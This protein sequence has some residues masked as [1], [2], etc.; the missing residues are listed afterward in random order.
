[1]NKKLLTFAAFLFFTTNNT[2]AMERTVEIDKHENTK[3]EIAKLEKAQTGCQM[4]QSPQ[5]LFVS[6]Q[7]TGLA[8]GYGAPFLPEKVAYYLALA[9]VPLQVIVPGCC[10]LGGKLTEKSFSKQINTLKQTL[11]EE[12]PT[13]NPMEELKDILLGLTQKVDTLTEKISNLEKEKKE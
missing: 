5:V 1:M 8:I 7:L 13:L 12:K 4:C 3:K 6:S 9:K 2:W 11:P 10:F